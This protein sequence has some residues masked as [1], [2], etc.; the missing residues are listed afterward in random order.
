[1]VSEGIMQEML[2]GQ[3]DARTAPRGQ[4]GRTDRTRACIWAT[5]LLHS[6]HK[7]GSLEGFLQKA[8]RLVKSFIE[9]YINQQLMTKANEQM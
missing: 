8:S 7:V 2:R 9:R 6:G 3:K 4:Q 5:P 1:M